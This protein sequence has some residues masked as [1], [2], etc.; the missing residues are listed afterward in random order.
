MKDNPL[1]TR[2]C[3][4]GL[5]V[6]LT[7]MLGLAAVTLAMP[8]LANSTPEPVNAEQQSY[9]PGV[10]S[11]D[12]VVLYRK[13]F[14]LQE[15]R[16]WNKADRLIKKLDDKRLMGRVLYQRYMHPTGWRS[17]YK[18]LRD[19][20]IKYRAEPGATTIYKLAKRRRPKNHKYP[21][22]PVNS[23][24]NIYAAHKVVKNYRPAKRM[25]RNR[26]NYLRHFD[27]DIRVHLRKGQIKRALQHMGEKQFKRNTDQTQRD[28]IMAKITSTMVRYGQLEQALKLAAPAAERSRKYTTQADWSAGLAAWQLG[29]TVIARHHFEAVMRS[30]RSN[31]VQVASSAVWSA[32]AALASRQP[33]DVNRLLA[34]AATYPRNFY[35]QIALRQLG[36]QSPFSWTHPPL[37]NHAIERLKNDPAISRT[38]ALKQVG[39]VGWASKEIR[40][41]F[42]TVH[43]EDR[44]AVLSL[45]ANIGIPSAELSLARAVLGREGQAY[46][47]ALYP[48]PP[49]KPVAGF[50]VDRALVYAFMRQESA[51]K[52]NAKSVDGARGL[53]QLMPRT[54]SFIARDRSLRGHKRN[55]LFSPEFNVA[56]GQKY[57]RHLMETDGV[58][59]N[60][61]KIAAAYNGGPGNLRKWMRK[62]KDKNDPLLFIES[63]PSLETR[64]FIRRVL[65]N[66]WIYRDR[67]GQPTPSLD[68]IASGQ[69]PA[70]TGLDANI[71]KA[72]IIIQN[73]KNR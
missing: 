36:A 14:A 57:L 24:K 52:P 23:G 4:R 10:L 64:T 43:A 32:R 31:D 45:A 41:L 49:W 22:A 6:V 29:E 44:V 40:R 37:D 54:A 18:Q 51:F 30:H 8:A 35:G 15:K 20:M 17:N 27:R 16:Q 69:W 3:S 60:L 7:G 61:V 63:L 1:L 58:D 34:V 55:Q 59:D 19:W 25:S 26:R 11:P 42:P 70:Y 48:L 39:Q 13:I 65:G 73:V 5:R 21:P 50:T 67:L 56:L 9:V 72:E 66:F 47:T 46:D 28:I 53:M 71:K 62:I 68:A 2:R 33:Q 12:D 38:V